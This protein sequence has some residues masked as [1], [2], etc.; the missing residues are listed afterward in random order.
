[1]LRYRILTGKV[2]FDGKKKK[3]EKKNFIS[4]AFNMVCLYSTAPSS[5]TCTQTST[6]TCP[7]MKEKLKKEKKRIYAEQQFKSWVNSRCLVHLV[8]LFEFSLVDEA[9]MHLDSLLG[10]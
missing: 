3:P 6:H 7:L 9:L 8:A 4:I 10:S 1:M 2:Y 5:Q